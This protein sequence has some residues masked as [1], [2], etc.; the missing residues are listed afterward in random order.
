MHKNGSHLLRA[1]ALQHSLPLL[2]TS[3]EYKDVSDHQSAIVMPSKC[4][5]RLGSFK[6]QYKPVFRNN[7]QRTTNQVKV[8]LYKLSFSMRSGWILYPMHYNK[9]ESI[10][11]HDD[12]VIQTVYL[13]G[14]IVDG[15][16]QSSVF[17]NPTDWSI[18]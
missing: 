1:L 9:A 7:F 3:S 11:V 13:V 14:P 2:Q 6:C 8:F 12:L 16:L 5:Y 4:Q 18:I 17:R 10:T 15:P